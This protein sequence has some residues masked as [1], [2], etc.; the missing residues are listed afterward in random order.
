[1]TDR[2]RQ[3]PLASAPTR[4]RDSSS[5]DRTRSSLGST[6]RLPAALFAARCLV[7][8][9][10][11][12]GG[13]TQVRQSGSVKPRSVQAVEHRSA[14]GLSGRCLAR[15]SV[16]PGCFTSASPRRSR[17]PQRFFRSGRR[18]T[19]QAPLGDTVAE[20]PPAG[21]IGPA[22][23]GFLALA[24]SWFRWLLLIGFIIV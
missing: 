19:V 24:L 14:R 11:D 22:D 1:M 23:V 3:L 5:G 13:R 4:R 2:H 6:C 12:S 16:A 7:E 18:S 21:F 20:V 8:P 15:T 9:E 17:P 10:A